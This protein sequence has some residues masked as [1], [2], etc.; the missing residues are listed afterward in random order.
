MLAIKPSI[1]RAHLWPEMEIANGLLKAAC[2][3]LE[4]AH[5]VD[6]ATPMRMDGKVQGKFLSSDNLHMNARGYDLWRDIVQ[7]E[8]VSREAGLR[9]G[10]ETDAE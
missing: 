10:D 1:S 8:M 9:A 7:R 3:E 4:F 6:I 2:D 5:F